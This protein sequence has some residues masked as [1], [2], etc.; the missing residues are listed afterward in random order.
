MLILD[1]MPGAG[2]T[3]RLGAMLCRTSNVVIFPALPSPPGHVGETIVRSEFA[4][5][6]RRSNLAEQL[7]VPVLADGCHVGALARAYVRAHLHLEW[8]TFRRALA[9]AEPLDERHH[10]DEV[11]ILHSSPETAFRRLYGPD[12]R[13][14]GDE[15]A[16][17]RAYAKFFDELPQWIT[18]GLGWRHLDAAEPAVEQA[19]AVRVPCRAQAV[20]LAGCADLPCAD[21][22]CARPRSPV[23]ACGPQRIQLWSRGVHTQRPGD[24]PRCV[25]SVDDLMP[26]SGDLNDKHTEHAGRRQSTVARAAGVHA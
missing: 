21:S 20:P 19:L 14:R 24:S 16:V 17:L 1:G 6:F 12:R 7:A 22:L 8:D 4:E 15:L 18:P 25:R 3:R 5:D 2:A 23:L 9:M 10:D 26:S 13:P 11:L